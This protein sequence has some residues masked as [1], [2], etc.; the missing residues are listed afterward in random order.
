MG[1][2]YNI[3]RKKKKIT[4]DGEERLNLLS[5]TFNTDVEVPILG[6]QI[7]HVTR[8]YIGRPDLISLA[9]YGDDCYADII[10]KINGISN[11]FEL[12]TD[13]E[14]V[15]PALSIINELTKS[16]SSSIT[17]DLVTKD[18]TEVITNVA[19]KKK[20]TSDKRSPNE[21][22][23]GQDNYYVTKDNTFVIY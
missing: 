13:M 18:N 5:K 10:C 14:L 7:I 4:I 1:L 2:N 11:P 9:V 23:I 19:P 8:E 16:T 22:T 20:K 3:L 15:C 21:A 17:D 12:N 6:V